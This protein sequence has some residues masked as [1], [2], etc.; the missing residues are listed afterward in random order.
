MEEQLVLEVAM[1][2]LLV[3]VA[4]PCNTNISTSSH[5]VQ[6]EERHQ[7]IMEVVECNSSMP[8]INN[9]KVG[10][11]EARDSK[12]D[13]LMLSKVTG[14][15]LNTNSKCKRE[16]P[17]AN[18]REDMPLRRARYFLLLFFINHMFSIIFNYK[19]CIAI[20]DEPK[21]SSTHFC[22]EIQVGVKR[23]AE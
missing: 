7:D 18:T 12:V 6:Q 22:N 2:L 1:V 11:E 21:R 16:C 13:H 23:N 4:I 14:L 5:P 9:I 19:Y 15:L 20:K 3:L 8:C 10:L 17:L